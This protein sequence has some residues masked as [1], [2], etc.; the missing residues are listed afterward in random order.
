MNIKKQWVKPVMVTEQFSADQYVAICAEPS[1]FLYIDG[2]EKYTYTDLF[3]VEQTA[4]RNGSDGIFQDSHHANSFW[5]VIWNAIRSFFN[6]RTYDSNGE[7]TGLQTINNP[8]QKGQLYNLP[9]NTHPVYGSENQLTDGD[10]YSGP[11]LTGLL[12]KTPDNLLYIQ[13]NMS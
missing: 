4:Y 8:T 2:T 10:A 9:S 3:G 12:K 7:F 11:N 1:Q 5:Q 13:G 6:G